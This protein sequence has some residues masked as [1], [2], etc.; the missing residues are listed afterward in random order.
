VEEGTFSDGAFSIASLREQ[1]LQAQRQ[2]ISDRTLIPEN[3]F[4]ERLG[5]SKTRLAQL[6]ANGSVFAVYVE[7]VAYY[8]TVLADSRYDLSRLQEICRIIVP[9]GDSRMDLL[10]SRRESLGE[11]SAL[12]ML[13]DDANFPLLRRMSEAWAAEFSRTVVRLFEGVHET[14]PADAE[15][16]YTAMAEIDPRKPVW[17]RASA[18]LHEHGYEWPLGPYP[19]AKAFSAFVSHQDAG[20]DEPRPDACVQIVVDG[21][22]I[23]VRIVFKDG[24]SQESLPVH[25]GKGRSVVDVAKKAISYLLGR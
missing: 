18:A 10:T 4:R 19:E 1:A 14:A 13:G 17:E 7:N 16:I 11:K 22:R 5:V 20:D 8:P 15:A 23:Q 9:A 21:E 2:M 24:I 12:E 3:Q 6:L 25:I